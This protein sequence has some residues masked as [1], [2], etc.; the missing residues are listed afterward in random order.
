M[1]FEEV[2]PDLGALLRG[3]WGW[4]LFARGEIKASTGEDFQNFLMQ[5]NVPRGSELFLNSNGG[6]LIGGVAL[7][8]VI[9]QNML[10]TH[11]GK[12]GKFEDGLQ[13]WEP[14]DCMSACAVAF[15]GGEYRFIMNGSKFGVHRFTFEGREQ[16]DFESAQQLSASLIEYLR[17]MQID[18]EL[19]SLASETPNDEILILPNE[20][21]TRLNVINNGQKKVKWTIESIQGGLYLKGERETIYGMQK[22]L[23]V[24]PSKDKMYLY[25]IFDAGRSAGDAMRMDVDRLV[26]DDELLPLKAFRVSRI[27]DHGLINSTYLM[28]P[29]VLEKLYQAKM[30][31][32]CLQFSEDA[33]VFLG[34]D[35]L[36]FTEGAAKL[37][38]L[39]ALYDRNA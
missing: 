37:P 21:L 35:N 39:L 11:V 28:P 2:P 15:L 13:S 36:P 22:F 16:R 23:I 8:R 1:D 26:I 12:K 25:I 20:T 38:G 10:I 33:P 29:G 7:G 14:G 18:S 30:V 32:L 5:N 6:S 34:F 4:K 17:E 9:R 31:G 3:G 24:F 27:D 19:F